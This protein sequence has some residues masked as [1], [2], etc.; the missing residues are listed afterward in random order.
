MSNYARLAGIY[1]ADSNN[2][3]GLIQELLCIPTQYDRAAVLPEQ[4]KYVFLAFRCKHGPLEGYIVVSRL[5]TTETNDVA[6]KPALL[7]LLPHA[8][9]AWVA[10]TLSRCSEKSLVQASLVEARYVL[11]HSVID[12]SCTVRQLYVKIVLNWPPLTILA[13][14]CFLAVVAI[15]SIMTFFPP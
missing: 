3:I 8:Y 2:A 1:P 11:Y 6:P 4:V 15:L 7:S 14:I 9:D 13:H 5:C 10:N 12:A